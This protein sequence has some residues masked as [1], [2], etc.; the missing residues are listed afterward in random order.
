MRVYIS[1]KLLEQITQAHDATTQK[2]F[3]KNQAM[4][5]SNHCFPIVKNV[6][7]SNYFITFIHCVLL[8]HE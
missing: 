5:T 4:E 6:L 8:M 3:L 2:P 1:S 7:L